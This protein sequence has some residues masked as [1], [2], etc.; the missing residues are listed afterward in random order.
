MSGAM[1]AGWM[2]READ[3]AE[4]AINVL[5]PIVFRAV[6]NK[7]WRVVSSFDHYCDGYNNVN[8]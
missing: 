2:E 7:G 4:F 1:A 8:Y 3:G 6:N 5:G